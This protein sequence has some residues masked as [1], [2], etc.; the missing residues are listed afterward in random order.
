MSRAESVVGLPKGA[1]RP[2][3]AG[4]PAAEDH[5]RRFGYSGELTLLRN[6][7]DVDGQIYGPQENYEVKVPAGIK[8]LAFRAIDGLR[9]L[10][11]YRCSVDV[12]SFGPYAGGLTGSIFG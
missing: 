12:S 5:L 10:V 1:R 8:G 9:C 11:T 4:N 6:A 2:S 3:F 7:R